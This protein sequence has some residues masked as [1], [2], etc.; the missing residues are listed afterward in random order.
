MDK[1]GFEREK[2][3]VQEIATKSQQDTEMVLKFKREF[4]NE[5]E[6]SQMLKLELDKYAQGIQHEKLKIEEEKNALTV[7]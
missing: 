4:E 7:M 1:L 6:K 3:R 2:I 5:K